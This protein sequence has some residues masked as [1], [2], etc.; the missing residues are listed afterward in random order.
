MEIASLS[1]EILTL[2][3]TIL[4]IFYVIA[5]FNKSNKIRRDDLDHERKVATLE[6]FNRLQNEALDILYINYEPKDIKTIVEGRKT[7][8]YKTEYR[9]LSTYIARIEHFCVGVETEIYDWKTVYELAHG[10]F[11][12]SIKSRVMQVLDV[13]DTC[14]GGKHYEYTR[15]VYERMRAEEK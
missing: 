10:F 11:D 1:I 13:K 4:S 8:E 9:K 3:C 14:F 5:E 6:A 7:A 2:I 12:G 15:K